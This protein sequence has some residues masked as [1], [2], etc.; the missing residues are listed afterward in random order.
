MPVMML[1][2][3]ESGSETAA[4]LSAHYRRRRAL[5]DPFGTVTFLQSGHCPN[6]EKFARGRESQAC[7]T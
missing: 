1:A 4:S 7:S 6:E 5:F 3:V 2:G